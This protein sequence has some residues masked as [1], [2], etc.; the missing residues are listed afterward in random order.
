MGLPVE[1]IDL[2][3]HSQQGYL[4]SSSAGLPYP[5]IKT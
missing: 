3:I 2:E 5:I 1:V 4:S